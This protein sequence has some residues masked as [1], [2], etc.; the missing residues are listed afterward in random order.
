MSRTQRLPALTRRR[1][2]AASL[3]GA[4]G[5]AKLTQRGA[6]ADTETP[7]ARELYPGVYQIDSLFGGRNLFQYLFVGDNVVLLD[8]GLAYTP[9]RT[10]FPALKQLGISPQAINLAITTHADGDHQGGN[11]SIKRTSPATW[12]ACGEADRAMVEDPRTLWDQRY[13][14][15]KRDYGVGI[16][17]NPS[18]DVGKPRR[19]DVC[20]AGGERIRLR[21]DWDLE[22]L[23]VPGHSHGHLALLDRDHKAAFAGDAIH[24]RGCPHAD[25]TMALPVTYY[26]VDVYLSTLNLFENL[27]IE[28][29]CSGHWPTLRGPGIRD[30]IA[31]SRQTVRIF[32]EVILAKLAGRSDGVGLQELMDA[33]GDA[34]PDWPKD[35][36]VFIMFA[37][38]GHLDR[39][40]EQGKVREVRDARPYKWV[41]A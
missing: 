4:V 14:F 37:A 34:F 16:D 24:G 12:L 36:R 31:E 3:A 28:T 27:P 1:F 7:R 11:D 41:R 18:P 20:L 35:T 6:A 10:I 32:D 23:H 39:L 2:V 5:A 8:T 30:F 26:Y 13:N 29:L 33:I 17:P 38:K 15:L 22:V 40:A 19:M 21:S 9:E 25:G